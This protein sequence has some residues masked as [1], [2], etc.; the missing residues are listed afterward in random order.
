MSYCTIFERPIL[1]GFS[2]GFIAP[3]SLLICNLVLGVTPVPRAPLHFGCWLVV[4]LSSSIAAGRCLGFGTPGFCLGLPGLVSFIFL[5][6]ALF[7][8][9]EDVFDV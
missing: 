9:K 5:M 3:S 2:F 8:G 1:N 4:P 7:V 6:L